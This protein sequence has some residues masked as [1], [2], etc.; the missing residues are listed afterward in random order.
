MSIGSFEFIIKNQ[1]SDFLEE[2]GMGTKAKFY[3]PAFAGLETTVKRRPDRCAGT[4]AP[5]ATHTEREN[6]MMSGDPP[7][8]LGMAAMMGGS[9]LPDYDM[10]AKSITHDFWLP[11][12]GTG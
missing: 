3:G 1:T 11:R 7:F 9:Y 10:N 6:Q 12:V 8:W 5:R 4:R 2:R